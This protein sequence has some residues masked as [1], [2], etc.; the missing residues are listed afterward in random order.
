MG[1]A[2]TAWKKRMTNRRRM[3]SDKAGSMMSCI[4]LMAGLATGVWW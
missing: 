3:V 1:I 2:R 4:E